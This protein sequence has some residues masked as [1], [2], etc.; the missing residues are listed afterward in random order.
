MILLSF[1]FPSNEAQH[2]F[3]ITKQ[4]GAIENLTAVVARIWSN[5]KPFA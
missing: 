1:P 2:Q 3:K 5:G 4:N